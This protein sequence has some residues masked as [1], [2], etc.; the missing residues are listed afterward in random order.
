MHEKISTSSSA[1]KTYNRIKYGVSLLKANAQTLPQRTDFSSLKSDLAEYR[2][3][4]SSYGSKPLER[5]R[6]LEIGF[7]Q[8]PFRYY[9]LQSLGMD[10]KAVDIEQPTLALSDVPR[11]YRHNGFYRMIK[12]AVRASLFDRKVYNDFRDFLMKTFNEETNYD[13]DGLV[14]AD[15]SSEE[16]WQN[17]SGPFDFIYSEDVFEHIPREN[18]EELVRLMADNMSS[19]GIA[20]I[21]P[22]VYTGISGGHH[23]DWYPATFRQKDVTRT[24]PAWDHLLGD[25]HAADTYMN[26]VSRRDYRAMFEKHFE[27]VHEET[28]QGNL[29]EEFL[30]PELREKLADYDDYEL[31]SN[32]VLFVLKKK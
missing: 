6:I 24:T 25:E 32:Q 5:S 1:V 10:V 4:S 13:P 2:K 18:L 23:I 14:V 21:R 28:K 27:I 17:V 30:T 9:L 15:S 22:M 7:G 31:F 11:V 8:R 12:G 29:G 20:C 16:F 26:E 19:G 3:Y